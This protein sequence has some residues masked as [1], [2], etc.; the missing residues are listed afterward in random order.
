MTQ[1]FNLSQFANKVNS[2]GQA[3]LTTAVTGTLP[4]ANGGTNNGSLAVTAGGVVYTDGSKLAN[5][6]AGTSGQVLKSNGA[7]V[8]TWGFAG[9][10]SWQSVQTSSFTAVAGNGYPVNTTSS[11][12]TVTLPAS[13]TAGD[14]I[15]LTDYAGKWATNNVT[16]GVN[17]NKLDGNSLNAILS[18]NRQSISFVYIDAT[19]GWIAYSGFLDSIP[20]QSYT[21]SYL[22]VAGGGGGAAGGG[23]AGGYLTG[24]I[25][26][27]GGTVYTA[28]VGGGGALG[29]NSPVATNGTS[30]SSSSFTG[31]TTAVGGG[32]ASKD[33]SSP[34]SLAS[35]G[36]S[37]GGGGW[38][39]GT[40]RTGG[41]AT[42]G[43]GYAGGDGF[44]GGSYCAGGGGGSSSVGAAATPS[45][46]G[47]GGNGTASSITGTPA[48]YGGGGGGGVANAGGTA[49][50]GGPGTPGVSGGNGGAL[51]TSGT[52]GVTNTGGGGGG[53]GNN[54]GTN[55]AAG[56]SGVVILSVPTANY[57]GTTTG[58][59][60][61]TTSGA[62]T[63]IKWTTAG[64]GT[65]TA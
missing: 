64:S 32:G 15:T 54:P 65:Y 45:T 11:T 37:G 62:N 31:L 22:V 4:I 61:I 13:P 58:S 43:Q 40:G 34:G 59:P 63:I 12:I 57:S 28:V 51:G 1:A 27:S 39:T 16:V 14:S 47:V 26:L 60:T 46:G 20:S 48:I 55:G 29:T 8:P 35:S 44:N 21:A 36:G 33:A 17:G 30:G 19:Q 53:G 18:T 5:V 41:A 38:N 25:S 42:P 10:I 52:A 2:S 6:G 50:L 56:A 23:G 24:T 3:D 49:G 9:A 7:S